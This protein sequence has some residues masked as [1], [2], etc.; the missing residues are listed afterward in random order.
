MQ[1]HFTMVVEEILE[2][3]EDQAQII[4]DGN[5][6]LSTYEEPDG[7]ALEDQVHQA[8]D[9][10]K[11]LINIQEMLQSSGGVSRDMASS[12]QDVLPEG[13]A[14]ESFTTR[15]THTNH[16]MCLEFIGTAI[17]LVALTGVVAILGS[18]GYV[19]YRVVKW[20][21]SLP[22]NKLDKAVSGMIATVE[23]K[24][25]S[26]VT[27]LSHMFPEIEH[28]EMT[29]KK[30]E[31]VVMA[32]TTVGC[33]EI[34]IPML[35]GDYKSLAGAAGS[36][37]MTQAQEI[38]KFFKDAIFPQL[39]KM[40]KGGTTKDLDHV[41]Q[42]LQEFK[43]E[44]R[45]STHLERFGHDM[46][47]DFNTPQQVCEKFRGK[48]TQPV[49]A[50]E[51]P[52]RLG[53][54]KLAA[55]PLPEQA[56]Q[57]M[58]KAQAIM[59]ELFGRIQRYEKSMDKSKELP[60]DYIAEVRGLLTKCKEPISSLADVFTITEIEVTS[61][62]RCCK[63]KATGAANGFKSVSEYYQEKA[64]QDKDNSKQYNECARFLKKMFEP[65]AAALR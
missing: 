18:I 7:P 42:K 44:D 33:Q 39:D 59:V 3:S 49:L 51:L 64:K 65:L 9:R 41:T 45:V 52:H 31:G 11:E 28:K 55:S 38:S 60:A 27:E 61:Q 19:V 50:S 36:E 10:E 53:S 24:L 30:T 35:N 34:D 46:Q 22:N 21:K 37:T 63:I 32:A 47:L 2:E 15:V 14:L 57:T 5:L 8:V 6:D 54:S 40:V 25:K 17:K 20:K 4:A 48:Y 58:F 43:F 12:F 29:W 1:D 62:K 23:E 16:A 13:M 26:A 56:I